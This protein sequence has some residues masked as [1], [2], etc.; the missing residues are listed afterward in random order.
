MQVRLNVFIHVCCVNEMLFTSLG[1]RLI[2]VRI[3]KYRFLYMRTRT[4]S[5][6]I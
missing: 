6:Y 2:D 3:N 1:G 5:L 4:F